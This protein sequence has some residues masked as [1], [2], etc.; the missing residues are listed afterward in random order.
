MQ[1][2]KVLKD[3]SLVSVGTLLAV[4]TTFLTQVLLSWW[5]SPDDF[6]DFVS[7]LAL[8]TTLSTIAIFGL[9]LIVL[10]RYGKDTTSGREALEIAFPLSIVISLFVM[11]L[12]GIFSYFLFE[13]KYFYPLSLLS[14]G[15]AAFSVWSLS[16]VAIQVDVNYLKLAVYQTIQPFSRIVLVVI[17]YVISSLLSASDNY[18]IYYMA[19]FLA[20]LLVLAISYEGLKKQHPQLRFSISFQSLV[21]LKE[22][23]PYAAISIF[24]TIYMG[25][26]IYIV[27]AVCSSQESGVLGIAL[28][29][30][31][32]VYIVPSVIYQKYLLKKIH[33]WS[34]Y[35][36]LF[37]GRFFFRASWVMATL[38]VCV[39]LLLMFLAKYL[40]DLF[41]SDEYY[42]AGELLGVLALS[43]PFRY[44]T[45]N[46]GALLSTGTHV[47][48]KLKITF[49]CTLLNV[50]PM[51]YFATLFGVV[52]VVW[53]FVFCELLMAVIYYVY[54]YIW[55]YRSKALAVYN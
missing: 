51:I 13:G 22:A 35:S 18:F 12:V 25:A 48:A 30:I 6:G 54:V 47:S 53:Y 1:K 10:K 26:M 24:H 44:L 37:L 38:G 21:L 31:A 33:Y 11:L 14:I 5:M 8:V 16:N 50:F 4:I 46:A 20:G 27:N 49:W 32:S 34:N 41:F 52:G 42:L 43:I 29:F 23:A 7:L 40:V 19:Y 36:P 9:D 17:A 2:A 15:V 3:T 45:M 55:I 28:F 39:A